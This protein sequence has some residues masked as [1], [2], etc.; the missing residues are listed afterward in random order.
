MEINDILI[1]LSLSQTEID[2]ISSPD[3]GSVVYNST[4]GKVNYYEG[5]QWIDNTNS[6]KEHGELYFKQN[7][8]ETSLTL[9]TPVKITGMTYLSGQSSSN[10]TND[11]T[12]QRITYTGTATL[13]FKLTA[14]ITA[15]NIDSGSP[16]YIFYFAKNGTLIN[17]SAIEKDIGIPENTISFQCLT[18]MS[19]NDYIEVWVE[20]VT[21][22]DD[23]VII[24]FN[25]IIHTI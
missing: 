17:K 21:D 4:T 7:A 22:N 19:R 9:N 3:N 13:D 2:N 25:A 20:N 14:S 16:D 8:N 18:T 15:K 10:I 5:G 1:L 11:T 12:N 24:D 23:I 6:Q